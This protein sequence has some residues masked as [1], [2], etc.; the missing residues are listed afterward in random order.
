MLLITLLAACGG[1]GGGG[2]GST[3]GSAGSGASSS[4]P[5]SVAGGQSSTQNIGSAGGSV[6]LTTS[7]GVQFALQ[8]PAGALSASTTITLSTASATA[9][10]RFH[11][12]LLPEGLVLQ[13]GKQAT[14]T[15]T[16]PANLSLP[17]KGGLGY[18]GVPVPYTHPGATQWQIQLAQFA[19]TTAIAGSLEKLSGWLTKQMP[20]LTTM[21]T[22][23]TPC[24]GVP[25]IGDFTDGGLTAA[26]V[27]SAEKYGECMVGAVQALANTGQY[28]EAVKLASA[29]AAYLQSTA[30]SG[31]DG[32]IAQA[33]AAACA[34]Y[35]NVLDN[36]LATT[37]SSMGTLN[38][39]VRPI[40]FWE[41]AVE[42]LGAS[43]SN[44]S[45]TEY[46]TVINAKVAE[47]KAHYA[48]QKASINNVDDASYSAAVTEAKASQMTMTQ[49][50]SLQPGATVSA[51]VDQAIKQ[52]AQPA[53][54]D[55]ILQAPW[56]KCQDSGDYAGLIDLMLVMDSPA[57]VK[58]AA[59]YCGTTLN[60]EARES[61]GAVASNLSPTLGGSISN[62]VT[63]ATA[64][65]YLLDVPKDGR[66]SLSGPI[67]TL[68]CP[69][70]LSSAGETL[71]VRFNG[72][73]VQ[74]LATGPYLSSGIELSV[75]ALLNGAGLTAESFTDGLL[76]ISRTGTPC[77]GFWGIG[78]VELIRLNI[79]PTGDVAVFEV[80]AYT[81]YRGIYPAA[82]GSC[83]A[84][85]TYTDIPSEVTERFHL[86]FPKDGSTGKL[87]RMN[88]QSAWWVGGATIDRILLSSAWDEMFSSLPHLSPLPDGSYPWQWTSAPNFDTTIQRAIS[89]NYTP[90][91][92]SFRQGVADLVYDE[93]STTIIPPFHP[94]EPTITVKDLYRNKW[95]LTINGNTAQILE[96]PQWFHNGVRIDCRPWRQFEARRIR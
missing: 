44:V 69:A 12:R 3:T 25:A 53:L 49:A 96:D 77:A 23:A 88:R 74:T 87:R 17:A 54:L 91:A 68:Q 67:R 27:V 28:A 2:G 59:Q 14:L 52:T 89:F 18:D 21:T 8:I 60:A 6:T 86:T 35:R 95:K 32:F 58:S 72:V 46:Q 75:T 1:G 57:A 84:S 66:I 82:G 47:A 42:Q 5:T 62:G 16:L 41:T 38:T 33:S 10:Q 40:L 30:A 7:E 61:S 90:G 85:Y 19:G 81:E 20:A 65:G 4:A 31:A 37:V 50:L 22:T 78:P 73:L 79:T 15:V 76:T 9:S 63:R 94:G 29:T 26:E 13:G 11:L 71:E 93:A 36:A 80:H 48:S 51:T 70:G 64:Q 56:K 55:A 24:N 83:G 39:L 34:A 92:T 45:S 43:C